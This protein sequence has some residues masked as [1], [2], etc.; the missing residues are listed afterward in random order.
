MGLT[1]TYRSTNVSGVSFGPNWLSNLDYPN[2]QRTGVIFTPGGKLHSNVT[3]I[4]PNGVK[5]IYK[6]DDY[7]EVDGYYARYTVSGAAATGTLSYNRTDGWTLDV[8]KKIYSY[9]ELLRL[10]RIVDKLTGNTLDF[11]Q[12]STTVTKVT[13]VAGKSIQFIKGGNNRVVQVIDPAGNTWNYAYNAAG[14]LT[15]VTSPGPSPDIREYH[16]ENGGFP[17]LLT[18]ISINSIRHSRY[19]Y[20]SDGRVQQSALEGG[21]EVDNFTYGPSSTT[22]TDA[23]GQSTTYTYGTIL[24]EKKITAVS[25]AGTSTCSAA[26]SQTGYDANGYPDFKIDWKGNRTELSYNAA[27]QLTD[28]V[29]ASGTAD[30]GGVRHTWTGTDITQTEY[31]NASGGAFLRVD[32]TYDD[33]GRP[34]SETYI[35]LKT[36]EQRKVTY[37]YTLHSNGTIESKS[38]S[39]SVPGGMATSTFRYDAQGYLVS[40]TNPLNQTEY[41]SEHNG[42][43]LP[44]K[45]TDLNGVVTAYTYYTNGSLETHVKAGKLTRWTYAH[46]GQIASV[47]FPDGRVA[48]YTYNAAGRLSEVGNALGEYAKIDVNGAN[49]SRRIS[50]LRKVPLLNGSALSSAVDGE[51]SETTIFDSLGRPYTELGNNGQ[52]S[53][54]RYDENGNLKTVTDASGRTTSFDYD[55]QNRVVGTTIPGVGTTYYGYNTEGELEQVTDPRGL[56]TLYSYNGFGGVTSRVSP[57][58]GTTSYSYDAGGRVA[59]ETSAD[60]SVTQYSWDNL[61]RM[62]YK[63]SGPRGYSYT[64]DEGAYG[65]GR[66]TRFNDWTH[67]TRFRFNALGQVEEQINNIYNSIY[68]TTYTYDIAGRRKTMSYPHGLI[69]TYNYDSYGRLASMTSNLGGTSALLAD[70]FLYQPATDRL[71]GWRFGNGVARMKTFDKDGRIERLSSPG[72]HDLSFGYNNTG[73]IGAVIDNVYATQTNHYT[74]DDADHLASV[75]RTGQTFGWGLADTRT[76]QDRP[77]IGKFTYHEKPDSNR[78]ESW[79]GANQWRAFGYDSKGN[80]TG[81]G[82]HD[83]TRNYIYDEFNRLAAFF[84]NGAHIGDYRN[85]GLNQRVVKIVGGAP[86]HYIYGLDGELIMELGPNTTHYV[87]VG[88]ELMGISRAGQFYAAHSDQV[89]R[90]QV[91]TGPSGAIAWRADDVA[92]DRNVVVDTIGGFNLGFPGQYF[93]A[94]SG[95]WYNW[96]RYYDASLGRYIQSDPIGLAGGINTYAYAFGNPLSLI[97]PTGLAVP[98]AVAG[99]ASNPLCAAAVAAT[100]AA[101]VKACAD[102]TK[103]VKK[104]WMENRVKNPPDVGPPGGWIQGPR[105]GRQYGPNGLPSLDIDKPHQGNE[106][107][108]AHEWPDG[109]REEPGRPVTPWPPSK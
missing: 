91:L 109:V 97:D 2:L 23:R 101:G 96:N 61:D 6:I 32:Y 27:G 50:S 18:G 59:T 65:K 20:Y 77:G 51:F 62:I 45:Y 85:N 43:G 104:W 74:Y 73:T 38:I 71:F 106:V 46:D 78:L 69:V 87:W 55:G 15:R 93:D 12:V 48:R 64:Y 58:T 1:R 63:L 37:G 76:Y 54:T 31:L 99:C 67:E 100:A 75:D 10:T 79:F 39:R 60:G 107:D 4:L 36:G 35:D 25:R 66:L 53:N 17:T 33:T 49:N 92:Y 7:D 57:D 41:W 88:S 19:A 11:Q 82:R 90:P 16:Y 94:E 68:T 44:G 42:L 22:V 13:N 28:S 21:E 14:M 89:N 70:S 103:A 24:G 26:D 40:K 47:S 56:R 29:V 8:D 83:G 98:L 9:N 5:Y 105:R 86:T 95:L 52:Q 34:W 81:E 108:H 80:V 3:I 102:T 72:K 84:I 30:A